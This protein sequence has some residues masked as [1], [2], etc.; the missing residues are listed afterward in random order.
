MR[1]K[2]VEVRIELFNKLRVN[3]EWVKSY[4]GNNIIMRGFSKSQTFGR[5]PD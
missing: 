2:A 1:S 4:I 3:G 5:T